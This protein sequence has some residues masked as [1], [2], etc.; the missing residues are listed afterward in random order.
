MMSHR[1]ARRAALKFALA[2]LAVRQQIH[3][4]LAHGSTCGFNFAVGRS[5]GKWRKQLKGQL[6]VVAK[7]NAVLM[8][9]LRSALLMWSSRSAKYASLLDLRLRLWRSLRR[10]RRM[11]TQTGADLAKKKEG[12][13]LFVLVST[14]KALRRMVADVAD[15]CAMMQ[16][17]TAHWRARSLKLALFRMRLS[18]TRLHCGS[19]LIET[20]RFQA[21]SS[22]F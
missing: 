19:L 5:F 8:A 13:Q 20:A 18:S 10:L 11:V 22:P 14:K 2:R 4:M 9:S 15:S 7:L 17:G 1:M 3:C 12:Q 21:S 6:L 16:D